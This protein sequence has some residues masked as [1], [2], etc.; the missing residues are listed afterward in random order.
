MDAKVFECLIFMNDYMVNNHMC[1]GS[2]FLAK[3]YNSVLE[4]LRLNSF[5]WKKVFN[6]CVSL[7]KII[8]AS[9]IEVLDVRTIG[10]LHIEQVLF[11]CQGSY[12]I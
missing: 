10:H 3:D 9:S 11:R 2:S 6:F 5:N 8:L 12:V 4:A 7:S 1:I